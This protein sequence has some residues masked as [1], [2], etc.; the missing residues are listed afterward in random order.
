MEAKLVGRTAKEIYRVAKKPEN[1][2]HGATK[3]PG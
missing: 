2:T 1:V 3:T